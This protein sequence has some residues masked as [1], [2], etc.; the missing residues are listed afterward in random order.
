MVKS[1]YIRPLEKKSIY[2]HYL[3]VVLQGIIFKQFNIYIHGNRIYS[4]LKLSET[5]SLSNWSD[6]LR[7]H[8]HAYS[9]FSGKDENV[10]GV[11][12]SFNEQISAQFLNVKFG[13]HDR[14]S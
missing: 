9:L 1:I 4:D 3:M 10:A 14:Y 13:M 2:I 11:V 8:L 7:I 6:K 5:E 12:G